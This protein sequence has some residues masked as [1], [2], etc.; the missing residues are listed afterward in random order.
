M[1]AQTGCFSEPF[2]IPTSTNHRRQITTTTARRHIL[3]I[4]RSTFAFSQIFVF[5]I[6]TFASST[7]FIEWNTEGLEHN[8]LS[9]TSS[10]AVVSFVS[11]V[12][13]S[14]VTVKLDP[15][16]SSWISISP[17]NIAAVSA[18]EP[19]EIVIV[20]SIPKGIRLTELNGAIH[21][22][23]A[24][25][26]GTP[27]RQIEEKITATPFHW[28]LSVRKPDS[29][30]IPNDVALPTNDRISVSPESSN[31]VFVKDEVNV[32]FSPN[33]T[34]ERIR[35][36]VVQYNGTFLGSIPEL[37][38]YQ[39]QVRQEGFDNLT[40]II[41]QLNN[42]SDVELATRHFILPSNSIPSDPGSSESWVLGALNLPSAWDLTIGR[43]FIGL[44]DSEELTVAV[45]DSSFDF[46][47]PDFQGNIAGRHN[48]S[49]GSL[50]HGTKV[51]SIIGARG[52][53]GQ[54]I[55]G[56]MFHSSMRLYSAGSPTDD[57]GL[58]GLLLTLKLYEAINDRA[59]IINL[60]SGFEC[61][62]N[63]CTPDEIRSLEENYYA[64]LPI[65]AAAEANRLDVL[66]VFSAGNNGVNVENSI[67]A[68]FSAVMPN[69]ISVSAINTDL[70]RAVYCCGQSSNYGAYIT[71][72][73]P[74]VNAPVLSPG[75][76]YTN[77]F[78]GTSASAPFVTGVAGLMISSNEIITASQIKSV[79][80]CSASDTGNRDPE[81]NAII[82]LDAYR[83]VQAASLIGPCRPYRWLNFVEGNPQIPGDGILTDANGG[84]LSDNF[85]INPTIPLSS[86]TNGFTITVF[87]PDLSDLRNPSFIIT[88]PNRQ[89]P[90]DL[91]FG[92]LG[93]LP[94]G[95][96]IAYGV[97]G[98]YSNVSQFSLNNALNF[99]NAIKPGCNFVLNDLH[100]G[101]LGLLRTVAG[102]NIRTIDAAAIGNGNNSF[103]GIR[104]P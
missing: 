21:L 18:G 65:F 81:G 16:F 50:N 73:A 22:V 62:T 7:N 67:P 2:M 68:G 28:S 51:A 86:F 34:I 82:L 83:A 98:R 44:N 46:N 99:A 69:V 91:H 63:A 47:H 93:F 55:A 75:G 71:V 12:N 10:H 58:D 45:I 31:V 88:A 30:F 61:K 85:D 103:P 32:R 56:V 87:A 84:S 3:T 15:D 59:K 89:A 25:L 104:V 79:I 52:N 42:L 102:L 94:S 43:R 27:P 29:S 96:T 8:T 38:T 4:I 60:S 17:S 76:E 95:S 49:G 14:N 74:G 1:I 57:M 40:T 24:T 53:N 64:W 100:L 26:T 6:L 20:F 77:D 13:L 70:E 33:T 19:Q 41:D 66:W 92:S 78:G 39:I 23:A 54:G 80:Q 35:E 9:G 37:K 101:K 90:C 48:Y 97:E 5:S 11:S 36:I 72:A